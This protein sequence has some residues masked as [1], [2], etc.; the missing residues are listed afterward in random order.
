[1]DRW[2][3]LIVEAAEQSGRGR[4]PEI[5]APLP[6]NEALHSARGLRLL[7]WE[8]ER[9]LPLGAYLRDLGDRPAAVSLFIGPEGGFDR[10]EVDLA[11]SAEAT[12]LTLGP[13]V[14]RSET[15]GIVASALVLNALE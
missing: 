4:P 12:M 9:L 6:L 11:R 5:V 15:A 13:R 14:L 3:H 7:P 10:S 8:E 2:R 1:M